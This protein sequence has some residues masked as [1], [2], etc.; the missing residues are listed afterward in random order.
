M[1]VT[2][3][4]PDGREAYC[5]NSETASV[6]LEIHERAGRDWSLSQTLASTGRCHFEFGTRAPIPGIE[7]LVK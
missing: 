4:D 2:Y 7:L 5:Y 3:H 6:Q 1:G